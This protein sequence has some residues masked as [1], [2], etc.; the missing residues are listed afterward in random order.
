MLVQRRRALGWDSAFDSYLSVETKG[1]YEEKKGKLRMNAFEWLEETFVRQVVI[2]FEPGCLLVKK[3]RG[4][5]LRKIIFQ[6]NCE[7][8][9]PLF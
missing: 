6:K 9:S 2:E 4:S 1:D 5:I 8:C 7:V 3:P